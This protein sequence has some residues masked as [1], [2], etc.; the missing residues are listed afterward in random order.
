MREEGKEIPDSA[1]DPLTDPR[2]LRAQQRVKDIQASKATKADAPDELPTDQLQAT[3]APAPDEIPTET[4][5][6]LGKP[7]FRGPGDEG[8]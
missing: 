3:K 7:G 4:E 6:L 1:E 8:L 5:G 2:M